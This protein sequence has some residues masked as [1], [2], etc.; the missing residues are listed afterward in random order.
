VRLKIEAK[1]ARGDEA[2]TSVIII[3]MSICI[4]EKQV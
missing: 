4:F 2:E 3:I 1:N